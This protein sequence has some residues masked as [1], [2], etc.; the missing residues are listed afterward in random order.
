MGGWRLR[1]D[2]R[3]GVRRG[4]LDGWDERGLVLRVHVGKTMHHVRDERSKR[5]LSLGLKT[6][7]I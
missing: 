6:I 5:F 4:R 1:M 3:W 2:G 7:M